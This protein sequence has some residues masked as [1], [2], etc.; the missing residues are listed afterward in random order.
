MLKKKTS[1]LT[2]TVIALLLATDLA[3]M[4]AELFF[5]KGALSTGIAD[6]GFSSFLGYMGKMLL[7]PYMWFGVLFYFLNFIVWITV[8]SRIDLSLA[9]PLSG[10]TYIGITFASLIFLHEKISFLRWVGVLFIAV[11]ICFLA[12]SADKKVAPL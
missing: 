12:N 3:A 8:L 6:V 10:L 4:A 9:Y 1:S 2:F 5:K 7:S 11:G